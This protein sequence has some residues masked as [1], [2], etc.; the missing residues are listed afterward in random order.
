LDEA[1][2]T[3][4]DFAASAVTGVALGAGAEDGSS[5]SLVCFKDSVAV[6]CVPF[7]SAFGTAGI[8]GFEV[9]ETANPSAELFFGL[10]E[11]AD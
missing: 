8:D 2:P 3:A 10:D 6:G 11:A 5:F 7:W 4:P 9:W 1:I